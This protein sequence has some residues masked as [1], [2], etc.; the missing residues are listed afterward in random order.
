MPVHGLTKP[1]LVGASSNPS[2][3]CTGGWSN[4]VEDLGIRRRRAIWRANHRGTKELDLLIGGYANV[5]VP[6]MSAEGLGRF[7]QF[8]AVQDPM[9]QQVLLASEAELS[10]L[11]VPQAF[12][13]LV[14]DIR[15]FHGLGSG[16]ATE[17][18]G[19]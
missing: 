15:N 1:R 19:A 16:V 11:D 17:A 3:L 13:E 4:V 14:R 18:G 8:L 7:E 10:G 12:D 9:L 6:S 2:L 5:Y